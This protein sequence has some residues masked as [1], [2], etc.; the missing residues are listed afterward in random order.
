MATASATRAS[1]APLSDYKFDGSNWQDLERLVTL[2]KLHRTS[3]TEVDSD[4]TQSTW[5][6]RQFAGP[7]LDWVTNQ[8]VL[9]DTV[10]ADFE[11]FILSV[12]T[13]FGITDA[14]VQAQRR[15]QLEALK[16]HKDPPTFFAEFERLSHACGMGGENAG[17]VTL[18]LSKVPQAQ[19]TILA[20]QVPPPV[21]FADHRERLLRVWVTD[22]TQP[23]VKQERREGARPTCGRCGKKGHTASTCHSTVVKTEK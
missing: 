5:V 11:G 9:G 4:V 3:G 15:T 20:R 16:W 19:L 13:H 6:A 14:L 7:A 8:L 17:K 21:S 10:F 18:L 23:G 1:S 22:P 2:A 12:R